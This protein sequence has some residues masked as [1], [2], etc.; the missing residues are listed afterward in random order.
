MLMLVLALVL[1]VL[2]V[3]Y[4]REAQTGSPSPMLLWAMGSVG[5]ALLVLRVLARRRG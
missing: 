3:V 4:F 2:M 1:V 5:G